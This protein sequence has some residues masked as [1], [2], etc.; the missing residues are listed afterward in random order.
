MLCQN[1][2]DNCRTVESGIHVSLAPKLLCMVFSTFP[3]QGKPP[4]RTVKYMQ[5]CHKYRPGFSVG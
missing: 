2:I 3:D 5:V 4:G 1:W